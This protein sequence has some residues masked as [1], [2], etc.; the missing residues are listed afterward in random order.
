M[1][2]NRGARLSA[3]ML[4]DLLNRPPMRPGEA[5]LPWGEPDFSGRMLAVHLDGSSVALV[6]D[7]AVASS[8]LRTIWYTYHLVQSGGVA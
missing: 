2:V 8:P 4:V 3:V 6:T 1:T 7:I 5:R